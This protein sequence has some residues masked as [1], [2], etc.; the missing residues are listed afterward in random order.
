MTG[1]TDT[2][3][4]AADVFKM[5]EML[6]KTGST[7]IEDARIKEIEPDRSLLYPWEPDFMDGYEIHLRSGKHLTT[8]QIWDAYVAGENML[9]VGSSGCGKSTLAFHLLDKANESV[10]SKNREIYQ[11]NIE[12][13]KKGATELKAYHQLQY[14]LSHYSFH[15][16][17]RSSEL[18]GDVSIKF[19]DDGS[20]TPIMVLGSMV[21]AWTQGHTWIGEEIDF[22]PAGVLG[23]LHQFLDNRTSD[24]CV[25][26]NGPQHIR[27]N[28]QFRAITTANTKG[29]GENQL[30]YAGTQVL[31][32][33]FLNRFTYIVTM[34]WMLPEKEEQ[35]VHNRTGI[36]NDIIRKMIEAAGKTREAHEAG[37]CDT[38][39]TT[40]DI[41]SWARECGREEERHGR[42]NAKKMTPDVYW[43]EIAVASVEPTVLNRIVD[44]NVIDKFVTFLNIR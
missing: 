23:Q 29:Q 41:L 28:K 43:R 17:S 12:L 40:R 33:A 1:T 20:R 10:R 36:R 15:E 35:L 3:T 9:F 44:Q 31:N 7:T 30:E 5:L 21:E 34:T 4:R 42:D 24:T 8:K 14:P 32:R 2:T 27:K 39:I 38:V 26:I 37:V 25:Y 16:E 19:N 22:A 11:Q 13:V 18:I 6:S